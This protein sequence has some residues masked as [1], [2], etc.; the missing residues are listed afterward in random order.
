M[1]D[2]VSKEKRSAIMAAVKSKNTGPELFVRKRLHALGYRYRLHVGSLPGRP[3]LVFPARRKIL[4][5]HGC[6][7]HGHTCRWGRLPTSR[8]E[9]WAQKIERNRSRDRECVLDLR[10]MGWEVLVVWQC[11]LRDWKSAESRIVEFLN[12]RGNEKS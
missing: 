2:R 7:W 1:A 3:D 11:E 12:T 5:I 9:F 6:F 4:L 10:S 8:E